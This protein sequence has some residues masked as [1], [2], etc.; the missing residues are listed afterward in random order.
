MILKLP[1]GW[2]EKLSIG[3]G[4]VLGIL[5]EESSLVD[6]NCLIVWRKEQLNHL[7]GKFEPKDAFLML[8]KWYFITNYYPII[9]LL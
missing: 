6:F 1:N 2:F 7:L 5:C 4:L 3:H 9:Y 8:L